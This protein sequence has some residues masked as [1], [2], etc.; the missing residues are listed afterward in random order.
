MYILL[1]EN[2]ILFE[3]SNIHSTHEDA[4]TCEDACTPKPQER[5]RKTHFVVE[6]LQLC[7]TET[8]IVTVLENWSTSY[9]D[10]DRLVPGSG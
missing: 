8:K 2:V 3:S 4:C 10:W 5:K 9:N 1:Y 7:T 6:R